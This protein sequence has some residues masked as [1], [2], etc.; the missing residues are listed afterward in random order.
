MKGYST[1]ILTKNQIIIVVALAFAIII[2]VAIIITKT[3][4]SRAFF[5]ITYAETIINPKPIETFTAKGLIGSLIFNTNATASTSQFNNASSNQINKTNANTTDSAAATNNNKNKNNSYVLVGNW[6][7]NVA[8]KKITYFDVNLTMVHIDGTDRHTHELTNFKRTSAIPILLDPKGTSFIG[9]M[10][11]K[12]NGKNKWFG[13]PV[14]VS[15]GKQFNTISIITNPKYTN[16]HFMR[17]PIYM[18]Y[19]HH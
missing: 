4:F 1:H 8:N 2:A 19:S 17:Q 10:D 3:D 5:K 16:N 11:I 7:L 15:I 9:M 14:T 12:L 13:V 18:E 6:G